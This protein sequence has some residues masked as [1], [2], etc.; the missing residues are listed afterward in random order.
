[1]NFKEF[2][3][4]Y[5]VYNFLNQCKTIEEARKELET[6]VGANAFAEMSEMEQ[7]T[8]ELFPVAHELP[9]NLRVYDNARKTLLGE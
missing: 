9:E 8:N 4:L 3:F 5:T 6:F 2:T 7:L 1:M